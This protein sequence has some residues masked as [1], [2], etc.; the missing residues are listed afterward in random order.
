MDFDP[1][2]TRNLH[3]RPVGW[4]LLSKNTET[5]SGSE[6]HLGR[7]CRSSELNSSCKLTTELFGTAIE[8]KNQERQSKISTCLRSVCSESW[9][10]N[11]YF[12]TL[13]IGLSF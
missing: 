5:G 4:I 6:C 8:R 2:A 9:D 11:N 10:Q 12:P 1:T 7:C 13:L 3:I